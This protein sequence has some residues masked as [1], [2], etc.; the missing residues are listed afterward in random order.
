MILEARQQ[1]AADLKLGE[2]EVWDIMPDD[3]N[4]VPC[5][6]VG[7]PTLDIDVQMVTFTVPVICVGRR[8]GDADAQHELDIMTDRAVDLVQGPEV[9]VTR[10]EPSIATISELTYPAYTLTCVLGGV[11]CK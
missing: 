5:Y 10:V 7:R 2:Y 9:A 6:V 8:M 1:I 4:S 11:F 3:V